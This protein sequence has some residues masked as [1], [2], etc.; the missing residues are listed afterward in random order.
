MRIWVFQVWRVF[1]CFWSFLFFKQFL[2]FWLG[3]FITHSQYVAMLPCVNYVVVKLR[4]AP[5][6]SAHACWVAEQC[7]LRLSKNYW[8]KFKMLPRG[9]L[10]G[11]NL[12]CLSRD[13]NNLSTSTENKKIFVEVICSTDS[14]GILLICYTNKN[15]SAK[16]KLWKQFLRSKI[17]C[18]GGNL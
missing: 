9:V 4:I 1:W 16:F 18:I 11:E 6:H 7:R 13:K 2:V 5:N 17:C 12:G 8:G 10:L 14:F 15:G 3:K